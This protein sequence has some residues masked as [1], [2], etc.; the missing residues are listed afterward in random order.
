MAN[1]RHSGFQN[2][3]RASR[4]K[5]FFVAQTTAARGVGFA[6]YQAL[7]E[8]RRG[9]YKLLLLDP[10]GGA[11]VPRFYESQDSESSKEI[12]FDYVYPDRNRYLYIPS[13]SAHA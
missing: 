6:L 13:C 5:K 3:E 4:S 12:P 9:R 1:C 11:E 10:R 7:I 2:T 8:D